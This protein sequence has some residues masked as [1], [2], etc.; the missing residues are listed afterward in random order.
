MAYADG[1]I[2]PSDLCQAQAPDDALPPDEQFPVTTNK[3]EVTV[4][5]TETGRPRVKPD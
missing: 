5:V 2:V 4:L 1:P 3:F